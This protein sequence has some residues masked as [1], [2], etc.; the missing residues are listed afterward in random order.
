[1]NGKNCSIYPLIE[2]RSASRIIGD[3]A[4][5]VLWL[6]GSDGDVLQTGYGAYI[7]AEIWQVFWKI[8]SG[9][10][11]KG[12]YLRAETNNSVLENKESFENEKFQGSLCCMKKTTR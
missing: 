10:H 8:E 3:A 7:T 2:Q 11:G 6:V 5:K 4:S 1:M 12:L 9:K